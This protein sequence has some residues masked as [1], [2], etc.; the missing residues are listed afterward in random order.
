MTERSSIVESVKLGADFGGLRAY[1]SLFSVLLGVAAAGTIRLRLR[2]ADIEPRA[3][4]NIPVGINFLAVGYAYSE[5][6]VAFDPSVPIKDGQLVTHNLVLAYA[7][8]FGLWGKSGKFDII[9][10]EAWL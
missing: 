9:I 1:R 7:R 2:A 8:S 6:N 3:Y 10:P 5:G 4:S